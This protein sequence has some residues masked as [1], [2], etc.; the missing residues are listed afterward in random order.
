M[1]N[2]YRI[3]TVMTGVAGSP[4]L[5]TLFFQEA[6]G[7]AQQAVT[8]VATFWGAVDAQMHQDVIWDIEQD[9]EVIDDT[10][11]QIQSVVTTTGGSGNGA[12]TD[13][14]LP[15]AT[16]ALIR[17]RTGVFVGGREIRGKT[18]IP[19]L[20]EVSSVAGQVASSAQ[21]A[22]QNAANTLVGTANANLAVWSR[23]NGVS[24][25]VTSGSVWNQF[26]VLRSRRD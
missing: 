19:A 24:E 5:N 3:R 4:Y 14:L 1:A 25:D 17:W 18:Y 13:D 8:A 6:T 9:V 16:Q 26:A 21:T 22:F 12:L 11:G 2:L 23:K 15:P 20:T 7:T 10:T